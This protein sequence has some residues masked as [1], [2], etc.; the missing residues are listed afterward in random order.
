MNGSAARARGWAAGVEA[1]LS[2]NASSVKLVFCP[3]VPC[4]P[5]AKAALAAS[6]CLQLGAQ[7][8][9]E[10]V[11]GP[12]TGEISAQM[13]KDSGCTYVI[14]GHSERRNMGESN[15]RVLA[16][17]QAAIEAGLMPIIC[18]GESR[19]A[20]EAK[21]TNTILDEQ[22]LLLRALPQGSYLIAYEPIWAIGTKQTPQMPEISAAHSHIKS[23]LGSSTSVL[24]GGSVNAV[25]IEQILSL[26][27]VSGALIGGA[28]LEI[29][30]M[31]AMLTSAINMRA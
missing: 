5:A 1:V 4:L 12:Y 26:A 16:K 17:A 24:Y 13:L 20:Y 6:A 9:H 22:L 23:V 18:I 8:C 31:L 11:S 10:A 30:S 27:E 21:Q 2:A 29:E 3:P 25:N 14:L 19:V 28:S 7:N 15:E